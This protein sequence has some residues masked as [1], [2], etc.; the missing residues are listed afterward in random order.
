MS[1]EQ[2]AAPG[3]LELVRAFVNT[4][5]LELGTDALTTPAALDAWLHRH[6]PAASGPAA[7]PADLRDALALREGLRGLLLANATGAA[8]APQAVD[9]VAAAGRLCALRAQPGP[10]GIVLVAAGT[11][12]EAALGRL[13]AIVVVAQASGTWPRLKACPGDGC[14]WALFDHTRSRTRTWCASAKCGA[15]SRSRAYRRRIAN[16][17]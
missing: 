10:D 7:T 1:D 9:A 13:L 2:L 11:G 12:V 5:D 6:A 8:P 17:K 3:E 4:R 16:R 15:R 14:Q